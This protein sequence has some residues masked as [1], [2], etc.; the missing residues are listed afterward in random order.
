M[1]EGLRFKNIKTVADEV[2][3]VPELFLLI[4]HPSY[5]FIKNKSPQC[6]FAK[7]F[8]FNYR[9]FHIHSFNTKQV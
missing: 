7:N 5:R 4:K 1:L 3:F 8:Y 2:L 6:F 9:F